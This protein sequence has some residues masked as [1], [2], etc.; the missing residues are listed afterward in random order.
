MAVQWGI[1]KVS[2]PVPAATRAAIAIVAAC[3]DPSVVGSRSTEGAMNT[4]ATAN[5]RRQAITNWTRVIRT[6]ANIVA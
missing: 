1:N 5:T 6:Q 2:K 4:T 3:C